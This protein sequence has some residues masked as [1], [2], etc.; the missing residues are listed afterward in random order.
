MENLFKNN[1]RSFTHLNFE[2]LKNWGIKVEESPKIKNKMRR[3]STFKFLNVNQSSDF[4]GGLSPIKRLP[5]I[6]RNIS[7]NNGSNKNLDVTFS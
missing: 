4:G 1:S 3:A 5:A 6:G 7:L 2:K